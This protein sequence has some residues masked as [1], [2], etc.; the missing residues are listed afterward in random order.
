MIEN[1]KNSKNG[2]YIDKN[3]VYEG[4]YYNG[5]K[6]GYGKITNSLHKYIGYFHNDLYSGQGQLLTGKEIYVGEFKEGL[7]HGTGKNQGIFNYDGEWSNN[8]A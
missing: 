4:E 7:R 6:E 3:E 2:F 5:I 1:K 8:K